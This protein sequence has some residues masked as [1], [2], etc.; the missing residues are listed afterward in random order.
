MRRSERI[1]FAFCPFGKTVKTPWLSQCSDSIP[2]ARK[3][4]MWIGLVSNIPHE[5]VIW[6][7]EYIVESYCKFY[8][9]QSSAKVT[10]GV[11]YHIYKLLAQLIC[12]LTKF[13]IR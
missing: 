9:S 10:A 3:N 1:V 5:Q 13:R 8:D 11:R 4:F 6:R 7:I 12:E 2:A